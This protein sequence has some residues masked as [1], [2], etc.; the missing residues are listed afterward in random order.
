MLLVEDDPG[1]AFLV[2]ELLS[3][4]EPDL[5]LTVVATIAPAVVQ[6]PTGPNGT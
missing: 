4:V 1:D 3:E 6:P 2:G 5:R